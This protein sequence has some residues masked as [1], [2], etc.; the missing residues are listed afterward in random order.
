MKR[1]FFYVFTF[2]PIFLYNKITKIDHDH[3]LNKLINNKDIKIFIN[4]FD[5]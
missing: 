5:N 3:E 4:K 2:V 1:L